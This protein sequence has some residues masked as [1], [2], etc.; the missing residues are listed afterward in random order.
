[1]Q[2]ARATYRSGHVAFDGPVNWPDGIRV[3]VMPEQGSPANAQE[4]KSALDS[5]RRELEV[6]AVA[7]PDDGLSNRDHDRL[8][9]GDAP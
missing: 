2:P 8:I 6:L 5:L 4:K 3:V 9:Y 1:M 7:N